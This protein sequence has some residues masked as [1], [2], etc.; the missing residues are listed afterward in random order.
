[1]NIEDD[2]DHGITV[3]DEFKYNYLLNTNDKSKEDIFQELEELFTTL[4]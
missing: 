2:K 1:M 3:R 4:Q